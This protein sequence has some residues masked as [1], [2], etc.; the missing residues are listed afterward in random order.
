MSKYIFKTVPKNVLDHHNLADTSK[1][2]YVSAYGDLMPVYLA[3]DPTLRD[4]LV[5]KLKKSNT[6]TLVGQGYKKAFIIPDCPAKLDRMK[7]AL[8]E[9]KITITNDIDIADVILTHNNLSDSYESSAN[10]NSKKLFAALWNYNAYHIP[11]TEKS[12]VYQ[13]DKDQDKYGGTWSWDDEDTDSI[14]EMDYFTG[15]GLELSKKY[16][17]AFP[18][19]DIETVLEESSTRQTL[20]KELLDLLISQHRAGGDDRELALKLLPTVDCNKNH[21]FLW[22][23]S[24]QIGHDIYYERR[25]KDLGYWVRHSKV[26][27]YMD[28]SAEQMIIWLKENDLLTSNSFRYLEPI[29]RKEIQIHNRELY[30]FK[31]MVKPEF[32]EYLKLNTNE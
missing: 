12:L 18:F 19:V 25:N 15:L 4:T 8:K 16:D 22:E 29:V 17:E 1:L 24:Q 31:C 20:T 5:E 3:Q 11:G 7:M 23:L 6:S 13:T 26:N 21:H 14:Y 9:H 10:I 32:S 28:M 27:D 2:H 30:V